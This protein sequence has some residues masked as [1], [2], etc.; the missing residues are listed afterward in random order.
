MQ[1]DA[2]VDSVRTVVVYCRNRFNKKY[3]ELDFTKREAVMGMFIIEFIT[4]IVNAT[5]M[6][7]QIILETEFITRVNALHL[8]DRDTSILERDTILHTF[9]ESVQNALKTVHKITDNF[10]Q[11]LFIGVQLTPILKV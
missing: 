7:L 2:V 5:R 3:S 6:R 8:T 10:L 11:Q 4:R 9:A 1:T